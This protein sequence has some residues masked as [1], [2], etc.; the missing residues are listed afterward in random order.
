ML[1]SEHRSFWSKIF[2]SFT[3]FSTNPTLTDL[4]LF[5]SCQFRIFAW[6]AVIQTEEFLV[7]SQNLQ[8]DTGR[9]T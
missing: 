4:I 1:K 3:L 9:V 2:P 5:P 8:Q 6:T 7:F